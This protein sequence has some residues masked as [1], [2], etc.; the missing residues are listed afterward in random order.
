[1]SRGGVAAALFLFAAAAVAQSP[2]KASAVKPAP[3][4]A[5]AAIGCVDCHLALDDA[6]VTPPAKLFSDDVHARAGFTCAFC[7][8]GD[9]SAQDQDVAHDK[10][11]G[12]IGK[13][14]PRDIPALCGKCHS[15][16][17]TMKQFN[18]SLRVDQLSEYKTSGHGKKLAEGD[19]RVAQCA[20]CHGAHGVQQVKDSRSPVSPRRVAETCNTCHGDKALMASYKLPADAYAK[21]KK[22]VHYQV[23][24]EKG[25]LSAPTC[26]SCHG[27]HGAA[28]P[29]V[30][31]VANVC[32]TCH[33]VF[34]DKFKVS[35]HW[36]AFKELGLPG[37]VTCHE[38][39]EI[40]K[41]TEAFFAEGEQGKCASCHEPASAG[42]KA[43]AAMRADLSSLASEIRTAREK[44]EHA[45][46]A[47]MEVSKIRFELS[48]ADDSLTTTR[49]DV[50]LFQ[51]AAVHTTASSGL[52]VARAA[53]KAADRALAERDYRRKGLFVSFGVILVAIAALV[54]KIK[55]LGPR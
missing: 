53:T 29:E 1:M 21:W 48:K 49:T 3:A 51:V 5:P 35:P 23:R 11:K 47:G 32:G 20:S 36:E 18:P 12:F 54:L 39:H 13:P 25:D 15:D 37:C 28:P 22:S 9:A 4:K 40:V 55:D 38:N 10:K 8:G 31:S 33:S 52:T 34:A 19:T 6:R 7:H 14:S 44:V 45:A 24:I 16:A 27:N 46:E 17:A 43:A 41:P 30:G 2:A 42:G 26:N 50:H